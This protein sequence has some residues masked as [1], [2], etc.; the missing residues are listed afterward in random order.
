MLQ[1]KAEPTQM[2]NDYRMQLSVVISFIGSINKFITMPKSK[3]FYL[4]CIFICHL[5][6]YNNNFEH[7]NELFVQVEQA[8]YLQTIYIRITCYLIPC[9]LN[10]INGKFTYCTTSTVCLFF[11]CYSY[12]IIFRHQETQSL[13]FYFNF[14]CCILLFQYQAI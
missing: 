1:C 8:D 9:L 11:T 13:H 3:Y 2:P 4:I 12:E 6:K 10:T 7:E 14:T 5:K